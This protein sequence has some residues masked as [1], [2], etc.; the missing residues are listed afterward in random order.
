MS[1]AFQ[2]QQIALLRAVENRRWIARC[3]V[4]GISCFIDPYGRAH[5]ATELFTQRVLSETIERRNALTWYTAHGDLLGE[6]TAW[7]AAAFAAAALGQG[8]LKR[9]RKLAWH[10]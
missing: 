4:G 8:F 9:K 5:E 6:A 3:A 2:H 1:G 7:L 10:T